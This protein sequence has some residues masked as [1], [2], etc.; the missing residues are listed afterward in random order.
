MQ[1]E[2][3]RARFMILGAPW[4]GLL[5]QEGDPGALQPG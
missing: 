5:T 3:E 2:I 1:S 4:R